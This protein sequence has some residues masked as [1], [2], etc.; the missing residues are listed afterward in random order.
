MSTRFLAMGIDVEW[1]FMS[2][3]SNRGIKVKIE[4]IAEYI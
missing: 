1:T 2:T 4:E 3:K